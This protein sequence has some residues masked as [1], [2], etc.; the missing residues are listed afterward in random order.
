MLDEL[1]LSSCDILAR[2][3]DLVELGSFT[4]SE[5]GKEHGRRATSPL[6]IVSPYR[7]LKLTIHSP[8]EGPR[9][10]ATLRSPLFRLTHLS[11]QELF[12]YNTVFH[13]L[14]QCPQLESLEMISI[15]A[16]LVQSLPTSL[17]RD[18]IPRLQ[19][20]RAPPALL[21]FFA[22]ARPVSAVTIL[23]RLRDQDLV[24]AL[25]DI[26]HA[27][28]PLRSLVTPPYHPRFPRELSM[29]LFEDQDTPY[30]AMKKKK[31]YRVVDP[32]PPDLDDEHTFD[33][34]PPEDVSDAEDAEPPTNVLV[35]APFRPQILNESKIQ[36]TLTAICRGHVLLPSHIEVLRLQVALQATSKEIISF[37]LEQQHQH[38]TGLSRRYRQLR[39]VQIGYPS[40][41][42]KRQD[43][44]WKRAGVS[45]YIQ[46]LP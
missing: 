29:D 11:L 27:S 3:G 9:L 17:D 36:R 2:D 43:G 30:V 41:N 35:A 37:S 12:D 21:G 38:I 34:L 25:K 18:I 40:N 24:C 8:Y 15:P 23:C 20:L 14:K 42:W 45:S 31:G 6:Q 13:F 32:N 10:V 46:V 22:T 33:H 44:I 19:S 7:L 26:V 5:E 4:I 39:E 28:I 1:T 16:N